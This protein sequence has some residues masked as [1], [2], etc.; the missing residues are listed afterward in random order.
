MQ[1]KRAHAEGSSAK[2]VEN[3]ARRLVEA[4]VIAQDE[5]GIGAKILVVA[6]IRSFW[7]ED[8]DRCSVKLG[9][10]RVKTSG[11]H[12]YTGPHLDE[13]GFLAGGVRLERLLCEGRKASLVRT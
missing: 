8:E 3:G 9:D 7:V 10:E 6:Q 4:D 2:T 11:A 5:D 1:K 13:T 12:R